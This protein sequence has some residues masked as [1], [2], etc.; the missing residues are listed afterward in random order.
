M[1]ERE[2][3]IE[4][5]KHEE[6]M[7][8]VFLSG[9]CAGAVRDVKPAKDIIEEM[10]DLAPGV[11]A[12]IVGL[13]AAPQNNGL[14]VRVVRRIEGSDGSEISHGS[15]H[16]DWFWGFH[17]LSTHV[18]GAALEPESLDAKYELLQRHAPNRRGNHRCERGGVC[19]PGGSVADRG[20]GR[21]PP[22]LQ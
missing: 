18:G 4:L 13:Q 14:I 5:S 16:G 19:G 17:E 12:R 8:G 3:G 10:V 2:K 11:M 7:R 9:Q 20:R 21:S 22:G 1:E 6:H 15:P